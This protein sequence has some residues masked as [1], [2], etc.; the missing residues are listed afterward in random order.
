MKP[1]VFRELWLFAI[2]LYSNIRVSIHTKVVFVGAFQLKLFVVRNMN[3]YRVINYILTIIN[4][5]ESLFDFE[6]KK[7]LYIIF[8]YKT[9]YL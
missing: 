5:K 4:S 6:H 1:H 8:V 3:H 2:K 7:L 9:Y